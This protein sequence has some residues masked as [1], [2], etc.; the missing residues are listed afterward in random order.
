MRVKETRVYYQVSIVVPKFV[1]FDLR[2]GQ[3]FSS[4]I[5]IHTATVSSYPA[6]PLNQVKI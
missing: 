3:S 6:I 2:E 1:Y 4:V 5:I